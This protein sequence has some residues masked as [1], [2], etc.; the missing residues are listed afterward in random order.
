[1]KI[2]FCRS[3]GFAAWII[4]VGTMSR[5]NH[6]AVEIDGIIWQATGRKG[7]HVVNPESL[8]SHYHR[9]ESVPVEL[10]DRV[11]AKDFGKAQLGKPYDWDA[12]FGMPFRANW[13]AKGKWFCSEL[14]A[15]ILQAGGKSIRLSHH[16]VTPRD[17]WAA[18]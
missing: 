16:R 8:A 7:V 4:R 2:H 1:M 14:V 11:A 17:L 12:V 9:I 15:A 6:V 18:V 13:Q 10:P 5:W 3:K